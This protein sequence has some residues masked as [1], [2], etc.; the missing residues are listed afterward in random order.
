[1]ILIKFAYF[2]YPWKGCNTIAYDV[3]ACD[4]FDP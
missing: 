4:V 3:I 2:Y 1:M